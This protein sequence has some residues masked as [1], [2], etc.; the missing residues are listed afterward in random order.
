ME[1][2]ATIELLYEPATNF[3][4]FE[5]FISDSDN[6]DSMEYYSPTI[7]TFL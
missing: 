3:R 1:G 6:K 5:I 7:I 2:Y 4:C